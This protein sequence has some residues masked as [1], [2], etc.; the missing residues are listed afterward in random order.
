MR[1][2]IVLAGGRSVRMGTDKLGLDVG[3]LSLLAAVCRAAKDWADRVVV[4][5]PSRELPYDFVSEEP[6]HGGPVAGI[7][8][9]LDAVEAREVMV[10]AGDLAAPASVVAALAEAELGADGVVLVD[11][12]GWSQWLAGR[13]LHASLRLALRNAPR[14]RDVSVRSVLSGLAVARVAVRDHIAADIDTP[15][16]LRQYFETSKRCNSFEQ[17]G[18]WPGMKNRK[19]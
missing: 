14:V 6:P 1:A 7:A 2:A 12:A 15:E 11:E 13:Y 5:G 3:G 8:A 10:L 9:A 17:G 4:A 18:S 19:N 16:Q